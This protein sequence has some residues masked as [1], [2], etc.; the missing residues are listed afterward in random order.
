M[1]KIASILLP[2]ML[3]ALI[4]SC[5]KGAGGKRSLLTNVTGAPGEVV[6]VIPRAVINESIGQTLKSILEQEYPMLPQ[7]EPLFSLA[8]VPTVNFTDIFKNHRNII[9][10][11]VGDEFKDA[12]IITQRD[13]WAAPQTVLNIVGPTYPAIERMLLE[14][15]DRL[16]HLLE[17]AERDRTVQNAIKFEA[18]EL[19]EAVERKFN[20]SL[21]FPT[22]YRMNLDTTNFMWISYETPNTSQGIFI[23]E[24]PYTD[25]ST[26]TANYLTQKRDDLLKKF[27][28]GPTSGSY[29]ITETVIPPVFQP[30]MFKN[31]YFGQLRGLWDV[32]THPMG[33]PF[34]SLTTID[35]KRNRVLTIEGYVYAPKMSKRNYLRQVEALM[36]TFNVL[37]PSEDKNN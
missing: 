23:Y 2:L 6:V 15:K 19:R 7:S 33:G 11:K 22:G 12:Q 24:Y 37:E 8:M 25:D 32:Y 17:Q 20:A 18:K 31:R 28:S 34:I 1:K 27:V 26:F 5:D 10:V 29:M 21:Y 4:F 36:L 13:V 14:E 9:L 3:I 35:E 30:L 16:V